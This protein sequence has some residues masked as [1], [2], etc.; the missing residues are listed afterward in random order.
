MKVW[1]RSSVR[2]M[3][4][5]HV[6]AAGPSIKLSN[7]QDAREGPK[8]RGGGGGLVVRIRKWQ[9]VWTFICECGSE[10]AIKCKFLRSFASLLSLYLSLESKD[11]GNEL[12]W[13]GPEAE[14]E[15]DTEVAWIS[16]RCVLM[17]QMIVFQG[18]WNMSSRWLA[19]FQPLSL[20][21]KW[22]AVA[23]LRWHNQRRW[24]CPERPDLVAGPTEAQ[25]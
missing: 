24:L 8:R 7:W 3:G 9:K 21:S 25:N 11:S 23:P 5:G 10:E 12:E 22:A 20:C 2:A 13:L 16:Q 19:F 17:P 15:T 18:R 4:N 6:T 1:A 14:T